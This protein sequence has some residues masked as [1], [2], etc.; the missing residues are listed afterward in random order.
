[1]KKLFLLLAF[2]LAGFNESFISHS[3]SRSITG[4]TIKSL[5]QVNKEFLVVAHI[6]LGKDSSADITQI[7][8]IQAL[9]EVNR[10]FAPIGVTFRL[11]QVDSIYNFQY[12]KL[13]GEG[14]SVR[15]LEIDYMKEVYVQYNLKKR[16]NLYYMSEFLKTYEPYCGFATLGGI[17]SNADERGIVIKKG[18]NTAITL[19]HEFG[20][21]FSLL[22]TFDKDNGIERV[23]R[24]NCLETGDLV[25]DT[26]ADPYVENVP[27]YCIEQTCEFIYEGKDQDGQYYDPDLSNPMSYYGSCRCPKFTNGQLKKM[28]DF[29][30]N[31][32]EFHPGE[33]VAW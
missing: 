15:D 11:C 5:P 3:F 28:A 8:I 14:I 32:I 33:S 31:Y 10:A 9:A 27:G 4:D 26:P 19:I 17:I 25:C 29:Y 2:L 23:S 20:H 18:C 1:M 16:I 6:V 24:K 13:Y 30:T 7:Q 12:N 22:H 21:F